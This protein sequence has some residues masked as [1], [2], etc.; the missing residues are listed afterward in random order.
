VNQGGRYNENALYWSRSSQVRTANE[1]PE[2]TEQ[3]CKNFSNVV[4][5]QRPIQPL[6]ANN[7]GPVRRDAP[8]GIAGAGSLR[9]LV[10]IM[11]SASMFWHRFT[12]TSTGVSRYLPPGPSECGFSASVSLCRPKGRGNLVGVLD[13]SHITRKY[14]GSPHSTGQCSQWSGVHVCLRKRACSFSQ[15]STI[16]T[17][18]SRRYRGRTNRLSDET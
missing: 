2:R 16:C 3:N 7:D 17:P 1:R 8:D 11:L 13:V 5:V 4:H 15:Q 6:R 12:K 14:H 18:L 10:L 9:S